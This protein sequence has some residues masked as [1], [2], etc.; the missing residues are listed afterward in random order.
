MSKRHTF[1]C[2]HNA[3]MAMH[4]R[5]R[6]AWRWPGYCTACEGYGTHPI[7][8]ECQACVAQNIC[9]R[10]GKKALIEEGARCLDCGWWYLDPQAIPPKA[11][12][13]CKEG[14]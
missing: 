1:D 14:E 13:I 3:E 2:K 12:C 6:W 4:E 5:T 8:G 7:D 9:P 11:T 10:C